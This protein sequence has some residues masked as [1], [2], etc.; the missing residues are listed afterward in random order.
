MNLYLSAEMMTGARSEETGQ[1]YEHLELLLAKFQDF[2]LRVQSGEE[3]YKVCESL[4]K[5]LDTAD[6]SQEI[7]EIQVQLALGR[8][9]F[10][11]S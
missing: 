7:K 10:Y 9:S 11:F 2:K 1:D 3:K 6:C 4:A 8:I 5:R